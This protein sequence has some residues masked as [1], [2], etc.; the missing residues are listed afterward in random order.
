MA[1]ITKRISTFIALIIILYVV[2]LW[3]L[4]QSVIL[5]AHR[6]H[7]DFVE[8]DEVVVVLGYKLHPDGMPTRILRDRVEKAVVIYHHLMKHNH[9]PLLIV[10]GKGKIESMHTE[11]HVMK[12]LAVW[13]GVRSED[14]LI[15][16]ESTNTVQNALF[17]ASLIQNKQIDEAFIVT[18]DYHMLRAQYIFQTVFPRIYSFRDQ[19]REKR[20]RKCCRKNAFENSAR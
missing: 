12:E 18:S 15:D 19:C 3:Y 5:P 8:T 17:T 1:N 6:P 9:H 2:I 7:T 14:I 13:M 20:E 16:Y 11:A 4:S 10:S